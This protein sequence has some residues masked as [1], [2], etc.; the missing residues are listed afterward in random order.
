MSTRRKGLKKIKRIFLSLLVAS[1]GILWFSDCK[2]PTSSNQSP[3]HSISIYAEW[4]FRSISG[5]IEGKTYIVDTNLNKT[6]LTFNSNHIAT[7]VHNDTLLWSGVFLI[8][9]RKS[10]YSADSLDFIIYQNGSHPDVII[11]ISY[12]SLVLGDNWFDG[13]TSTY[14]KLN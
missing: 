2:S 12:D 9:K 5:G 14:T 13:C 10:I 6:V 3:N 8:E 4:M 1:I 11:Y 7:I